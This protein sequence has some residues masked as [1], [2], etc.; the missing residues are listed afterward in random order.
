MHLKTNSDSEGLIYLSNLIHVALNILF[1][2]PEGNLN[3]EKVLSLLQMRSRTSPL[4][5]D[6][7]TKWGYQGGPDTCECGVKQSD[8][9]L[10]RWTPCPSRMHNWR[11]IHYMKQNICHI[12]IYILHILKIILMYIYIWIHTII[13]NVISYLLSPSIRRRRTTIK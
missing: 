2:L 9:F 8:E 12:Y 7:V 5:P 11:L 6:A 1:F 10:I 4:R 13:F 3:Q